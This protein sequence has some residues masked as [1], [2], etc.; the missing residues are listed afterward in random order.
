MLFGDL[1]D[2]NSEISKRIAS[3][4]PLRSVLT[5]PSMSAF[6]TREFNA[7][8]KESFQKIEERAFY[9]LAA[10]SAWSS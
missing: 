3:M 10:S 6:A 4:P 8:N 5:W 2:P 1:N 7:M 9:A